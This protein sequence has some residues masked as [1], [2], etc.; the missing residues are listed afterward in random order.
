MIDEQKDAIVREIKSF[1]MFLITFLLESLILTGY[2]YL[3]TKFVFV[4]DVEFVRLMTAAALTRCM[5][6]VFVMF[7][8]R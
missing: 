5:I 7:A 6:P 2:L 3:F 1:P 8:K 4:K